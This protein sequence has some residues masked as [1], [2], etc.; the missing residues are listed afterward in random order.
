MP[1]PARSPIGSHVAVGRGKV[2]ARIDD[3]GAEAIQIFTGNPRGWA[4]PRADPQADEAFRD[5]CAARGLAVFIHAPYL[6][7]FGSP[8][9]AT[10]DRSAAAL[11]ACLRRAGEIGATAVVVHAGSAVAGSRRADALGH[12]R[13]DLP[14]VLDAAGSPARVL[15]EPTA[16]GG[17]ALASDAGSLAAYLDVLGGDERVGV[18]LDTCHM[19]AAGHDL[20]ADFAGALRAYLKAAG[21]H[22][23][24]LVHANDSR[25]PSGSKRDRHAALGA[26]TI[27]SQPFRAL[28][29]ARGLRGVPVV[30]E[31]E[32]GDHKA[33]IATLMELRGT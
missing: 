24:G 1:T 12:V 33:D 29:T 16:G 32:D 22:G 25:D 6:I 19:H 18:C 21:R 28:F 3:L 2:F 15:I 13:D 8:T 20:A 7:N 17:G 27:G 30:V 10:R 14:R 4:A 23:V 31:T 9:E 5:Q 26:G 11:A